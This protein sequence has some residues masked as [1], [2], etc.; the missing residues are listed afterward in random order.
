MVDR[1]HAVDRFVRVLNADPSATRQ[2]GVW[3][4]CPITARVTRRVWRAAT[5]AEADVLRIPPGALVQDRAGTLRATGGTVLSEI[6]ALV[7]AARVTPSM[8]AAL[9]RSD[10]PLGVAIGALRFRRQIVSQHAPSAGPHV[11]HVRALLWAGGTPV[12]AV[13]EKYLTNVVLRWTGS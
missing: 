12:A 1:A 4:R 10:V 6:A 9:D 8:R 2:L 3:C 13:E 7:V 11:L 5:P